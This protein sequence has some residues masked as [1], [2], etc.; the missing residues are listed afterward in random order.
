MT[1]DPLALLLVRVVGLGR[2]RR[3]ALETAIPIMGDEGLSFVSLGRSMRVDI[4]DERKVRLIPE[5]YRRPW[6]SIDSQI[7]TLTVR[8]YVLFLGQGDGLI[9]AKQPPTPSG[10]VRGSR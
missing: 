7:K 4:V 3:T 1:S 9:D 2:S 5:E 6:F 10:Q 8:L